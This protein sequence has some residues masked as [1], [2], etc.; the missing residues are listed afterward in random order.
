MPRVYVSGS[1]HDIDR[2]RETMIE[3]KGN[4]GVH[5]KITHDWT[6]YDGPKD[7]LAA[8]NEVQKQLKGIR[9]ADAVV[10]VAHPRLKAGWMEFGYAAA[11][12]KPIII[13][14]HDEV[15]PSLWYTLEKVWVLGDWDLVDA[16]YAVVP[17]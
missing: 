12:E 7:G 14:P 6:H 11:L 8:W 15:N 13:I 3:V 16:V 9:E 2:V 1:V 5:H 17:K 10:L 4:N